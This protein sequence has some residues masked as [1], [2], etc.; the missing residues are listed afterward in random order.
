MKY[1]SALMT[2]ASG[3]LRGIV[4][5]HNLGGAYFR[6]RST[7]TNPR[8][9]FQQ[10][11]RNAVAIIAAA[12]TQTLTTAQRL[13]WDNFAK[14]TPLTNRLG[15]SITIPAMAW[16]NKANSIRLQASLTRIDA[17]PTEF[18]LIPLTLPN[19]NVSAGA[20]NASVVFTAADSWHTSGGALLI[21]NSRPQ[22]LSVNSPAGLSYRLAG[23]ILGTQSSPQNV[24]LAFGAMVANQTTFFRAVATGADGRP[25][26]AL[27][28]TKSL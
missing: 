23:V 18:A 28:I 1:K 10:A 13:A 17:A 4:A 24:T 9:A 11:V 8:T 19:I 5:S 14:N 16:Y 3:S 27:L 15:D 20:A 26:G 22:N 25:S 7:P 21:Y 2:E 6:G 12:W